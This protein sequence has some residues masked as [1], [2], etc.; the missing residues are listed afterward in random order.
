MSNQ[1]NSPSVTIEGVVIKKDELEDSLARDVFDTIVVL[2]N[3]Q[4]SLNMNLMRVQF[5]IAGF[6]NTLIGLI[7]N[8][9]VK[10]AINPDLID[11]TDSGIDIEE[12]GAFPPEDMS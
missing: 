7:N 10:G 4:R 3:E 2:S 12:T 9:P 8:E 11:D 6:S 1:E 5:N